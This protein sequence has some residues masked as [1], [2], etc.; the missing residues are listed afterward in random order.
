MIPTPPIVEKKKRKITWKIYKGGPGIKTAQKNKIIKC[1]CMD[2]NAVR[3]AE[4]A[5]VNRNTADLWYRHFRELIYQATRR[6]PRL[7][8]E[9]EMDQAAFGGRG[10]KKMQAVLKRLA[11]KLPHRE[12]MEKAKEVRKEHKTQVFGILQRGGAV[13]THIIKDQSARTLTPIVR[14]V[15]EDTATVY[16]DK[17]GGFKDLKLDGYTH[18]SV[19]H[20]LEYVAKDGSHINGIES[21]W[22]FAK[23]RL[24]AFRGIHVTVLPLHIKECEWRWN[25]GAEDRSVSA[26]ARWARVEKALKALLI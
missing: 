25:I 24:S 2:L 12:Y 19:N 7:F 8:G 23:L 26:K 5:G 20:S 4:L 10:R 15:V 1:F 11:K 21:F 16:T 6:A 17:W 22:S 18:R 3:A 9:V 13:Y 14:M